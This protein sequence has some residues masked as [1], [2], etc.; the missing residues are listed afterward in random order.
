MEL[1]RPPSPG[2]ARPAAVR[3]RVEEMVLHGIPHADRHRVADA[4]RDE[5]ARLLAERGVPAGL[6]AGGERAELDAGAFEVP[7]GARAAEV[8]RRVAEALYRGFAGDGG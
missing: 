7:R 2:P 4:V 3:V 5:L 8:G 6:R 1:S